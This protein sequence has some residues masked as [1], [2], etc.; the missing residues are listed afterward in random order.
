MEAFTPGKPTFTS[1]METVQA[2]M[3]TFTVRMEGYTVGMRT[4]AGGK[5]IF[6]LGMIERFAK[7]MSGVRQ[8]RRGRACPCPSACVTERAGTSPAP[9]DR[10]Y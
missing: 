5:E 7:V 9:T 1:E 8:N 2:E 6:A 3:E 10:R 4:F